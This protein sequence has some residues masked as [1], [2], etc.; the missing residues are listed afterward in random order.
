MLSPH[1]HALQS[2]MLQ[3]TLNKVEADD[4]FAS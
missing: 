1:D 3:C 4:K 2:G